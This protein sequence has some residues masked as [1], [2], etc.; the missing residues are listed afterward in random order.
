MRQRIFSLLILGARAPVALELCRAFGRAGHRVIM[1]DSL[2][3]PLARWSSYVA[4]YVV[5][6]AP[7][8]DF[9]AYRR[10]LKKLVEAEKVDHL[11]PTCEE[12]FYLSYCREDFAAKVW[13]D[14]W[15]LLDQL[16]HKQRFLDL[17]AGFFSIPSTRSCTHFSDWENS[18]NYVFKPIYSR[19]GTQ[20]LINRP[21]AECQA[22]REHPDDW[23]VQEKISGREIC[24]YSLWNE[25]KILAF[26][27]YQ[28][29]IRLKN[30]AA[31]VF[32]PFFDQATYEA[33]VGLGQSLHYTGQLCFD[34]IIKDG[35]P[36][37]LECNPRSTSGIHLLGARLVPCFLEEKALSPLKNAPVKGL[38]TVLWLSFR[39]KGEYPLSQVQDVVFDKQDLAPFFGQACSVLELVYLALRRQRSITRV[40]TWD[41]EWNGLPVE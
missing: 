8:Q 20:V 1:A 4:R 12:A 34:V 26:T 29:S 16:H 7:A 6:P 14:D 40:S 35:R 21:T 17:A 11:I 23:I 13:T 39:R 5:L 25:G 28:P 15:R 38:K 2:R 22:P 30:G 27:A 37:V 31:L 32:E 10:A 41:I 18:K 36:Y 33:V 24:V 19:F 9:P 3:W